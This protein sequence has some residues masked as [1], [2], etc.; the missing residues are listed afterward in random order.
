MA[1]PLDSQARKGIP[2]HSGVFVYFPDALV[3]VA[4]HSMIGDVKH[5]GNDGTKPPR[6]TKHL[7]S[8]HDDCIARHTFDGIMAANRAEKIEAYRARAWRS[9]AA[10]QI[11]L[12]T[13]DEVAASP[14]IEVG[15]VGHGGPR[16]L[17][18]KI[19]FGH[20]AVGDKTVDLERTVRREETSPGHWQF[21]VRDRF[22][23][24]QLSTDR[25]DS[26]MTIYQLE[27]PK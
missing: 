4:K 17:P 26:V 24:V 11:L 16:I 23:R 6:W 9:L 25:W 14:I 1:L 18:Q 3:E 22:G 7:S 5:N 13:P 20:R 21:V 27:A 2:L 15:H 8:D 12:E 10:L 19:W